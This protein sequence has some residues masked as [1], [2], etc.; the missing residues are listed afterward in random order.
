MIEN[1]EIR[2]KKRRNLF[3]LYVLTLFCKRFIEAPPF[4]LQA[5]FNTS[6]PTKPIIFLLAPGE[7]PTELIFDFALKKDIL[8][9]LIF[10]LLNYIIA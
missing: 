5:A 3:R 7:D 4:D 9:S 2:R 6:G 1:R 10:V 8:R